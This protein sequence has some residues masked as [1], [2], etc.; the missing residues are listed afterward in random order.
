MANWR[1]NVDSPL[2]LH[3][4]KVIKSSAE[5]KDAIV[6]AEDKKTA[7]LWVSLSQLSKDLYESKVRI[8]YL[9]NILVEVLETKKKQAKSKK[10][11]TDIH[12]L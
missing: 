9:E 2:K 11:K 12:S 5:Q 10:K 1:E 6:L 7:Q 8:K 4:E 3:L